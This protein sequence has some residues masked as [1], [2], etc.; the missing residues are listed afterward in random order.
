MFITVD[1][2]LRSDESH[3]ECVLQDFYL[4]VYPKY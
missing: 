4:R 1:G 2:S 3:R